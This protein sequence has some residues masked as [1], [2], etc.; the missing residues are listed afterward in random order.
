M[1]EAT[2][3]RRPTLET[4]TW[5]ALVP[6]GIDLWRVRDRRGRALGHVRAVADDGAWRFRAERYSQA[7]R[8]FR[9]V[10]EFVRGPDALAALRE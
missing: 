3:K 1:T 9:A 8:G 4:P 5:G 10:G 6:V 7:A 2:M